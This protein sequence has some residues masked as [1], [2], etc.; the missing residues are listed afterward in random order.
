M[1]TLRLATLTICRARQLDCLTVGGP[2][3]GSHVF[4]RE[5]R[6]LDEQSAVK[7]DDKNTR[8]I[9]V[10]ITTSRQPWPTL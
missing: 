4:R 1:W 3:F 7:L 10:T 5:L 8:F 2:L 6:G 9:F